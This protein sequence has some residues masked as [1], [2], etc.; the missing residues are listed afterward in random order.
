MQNEPAPTTPAEE[1]LRDYTMAMSVNVTDKD[2]DDYPTIK[3]M[4]VP[5]SKSDDPE[6][7]VAASRLLIDMKFGHVEG[8]DVGQ[9]DMTFYE[10]DGTVYLDKRRG[11]KE[12]LPDDSVINKHLNETWAGDPDSCFMDAVMKTLLNTI[13]IMEVSAAMAALGGMPMQAVF[14]K[15]MSSGIEGVAK[16]ARMKVEA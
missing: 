4:V 14:E 13:H 6:E 5:K 3:V 1:F 7:A 9:Q 11:T 16:V 2:N 8:D 12:K 15:M 10:P